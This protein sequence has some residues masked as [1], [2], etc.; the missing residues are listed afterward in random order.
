MVLLMLLALPLGLV[1]AQSDKNNSFRPIYGPTKSQQYAAMQ[2][3]FRRARFLEQLASSFSSGI[4]LPN[5]I[6]MVTMECGQANAFYTRERKAIVLCLDLIS[7]L[8][9][10]IRRDFAK[11]SPPA[12][13]DQIISGALGFILVHELGH[14]LIDQLKLPLLG[15]EEDAADQIGTFF[16]LHT[17]IGPQSLAGALWFF[18]QKTLIYTRAHFSDEHSIGPQRQSNLACW[19]I[20]KDPHRYQYLMRGGYLTVQRAARCPKEYEQLDSSVRRLLE[21]HVQLPSGR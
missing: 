12:E 10:G 19:A 7:S 13:I 17:A 14:A 8:T 4:T 9:N 20:G 16:M 5:Q 2:E 6:A 1:K 18:R 15:R 21:G 3:G 11:V